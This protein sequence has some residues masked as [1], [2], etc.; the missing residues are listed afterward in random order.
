MREIKFRAWDKKD[1]VMENAKIIDFD[2]QG[3]VRIVDGSDTLLVKDR[4]ELMQYTGLKDKN[5]VD[6]YEGDIVEIQV[7]DRLDWNVIKGK[8]VFLEGAWLVEDVGK[9]T[10]EIWSEVN[11]IEVIGNIY[12]NSDLLE[13]NHGE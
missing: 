7:N 1:K 5:G 8:V 6:I 2:D 10:I 13:V 3:V 4:M 11:E 12:E 9:F